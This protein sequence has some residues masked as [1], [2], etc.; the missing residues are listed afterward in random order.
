MGSLWL[1]IQGYP[2]L[3]IKVTGFGHVGHGWEVRTPGP[4]HPSPPLTIWWRFGLVVTELLT[5][6]KLLYVELS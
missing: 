3:L 5:S 1:P 4:S 2:S 6:T